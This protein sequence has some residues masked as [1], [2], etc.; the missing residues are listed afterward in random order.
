[1]SINDN[2]YQKNIAQ[3]KVANLTSFLE[4]IQCRQGVR[5]K[6]SPSFFKEGKEVKSLDRLLLEAEAAKELEAPEIDMDSQDGNGGEDDAGDEQKVQS[7]A[8]K[9]EVDA[10]DKGFYIGANQRYFMGAGQDPL[11]TIVTQVGDDKIKYFQYPWKKEQVIKKDLGTELLRKGS[12]TWLDKNQ[13]TSEED[14]K[15]SLESVLA[16]R[17][18]EKVT[19]DDYQFANIQVRYIGSEKGDE[20]PWEELEQKYNVNVGGVLANKQTYNIRLTNRSLQKFEDELRQTEPEERS[21]KIV[22]IMK[23]EQ[24]FAQFVECM[25]IYPMTV[26]ISPYGIKPSPKQ[27]AVPVEETEW[28]T[29]MIEEGKRT[30]VSLYDYK[31]GECVV[32]NNKHL[33][34]AEFISWM[35]EPAVMLVSQDLT[36]LVDQVPI[37]KIRKMTPEELSGL[38]SREEMVKGITQKMLNL[39]SSGTDGITKDIVKDVKKSKKGS[40]YESLFED[41]VEDLADFIDNDPEAYKKDYSPVAR[42]LT[43]KWNEGS[44]DKDLALRSFK[45]IAEAASKRFFVKNDGMYEGQTFGDPSE[46]FP[47]EIQTKVANLLRKSFENQAHAGQIS[48]AIEK[49]CINVDDKEDGE[50]SLGGMN[51]PG[52]DDIDSLSIGAPFSEQEKNSA[53][54]K[55][56][57]KGQNSTVK[58]NIPFTEKEKAALREVSDKVKTDILNNAAVLSWDGDEGLVKVTVSKNPQPQQK[59]SAYSAISKINGELDKDRTI[60]SDSFETEDDVDILKEFLARLNLNEEIELTEERKHP[61]KMLTHLKLVNAYPVRNDKPIK[62]EVVGN[63]KYIYKLTKDLKDNKKSNKKSKKKSYAKHKTVTKLVGSYP[64]VDGKQVHS[65]TEG[66]ITYRYKTR[67]DKKE[68]ALKRKQ[69]RKSKGKTKSYHEESEVILQSINGDVAQLLIDGVKTAVKRHQDIS[70][71]DGNWTITEILKP[72]DTDEN[73]GGIIITKAGKSSEDRTRVEQVLIGDKINL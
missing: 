54:E 39:P 71:G 21:F 35:K 23:E 68:E 60:N 67:L 11:L 66:G 16:G 19:L 10:E 59:N 58:E 17:P 30:G 57:M 31:V 5:Q 50:G 28:L 7:L 73:V 6:K 42:N 33:V 26:G 18:G 53:D 3:K 70:A 37:K 1:M 41:K 40:L 15:N 13:E 14:L 22:K 69:Q 63:I 56:V 34:V 25:G 20:K 62:S 4:D 46:M 44:Y 45:N 9:K 49:I 65:H 24:D 55:K 48:E 64:I 52:K 72:E 8:D 27:R 61:K 36:E 29:R 2:S 38:K 43:T 47:E 12:K 51:G 32:Y